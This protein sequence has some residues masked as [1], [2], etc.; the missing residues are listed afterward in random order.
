MVS[1]FLRHFSPIFFL[2]L[3]SSSEHHQ[4]LLK[5]DFMQKTIDRYE[6]KILDMQKQVDTLSQTNEVQKEE[7]ERLN[8]E[9]TDLTDIHQ[10]EMSS[11]K[12]DLKKLEDKL[13]YSFNE[14]WTEMVE[15]LEKLDTRVCIVND[16]RAKKNAKIHF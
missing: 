1:R 9:L 14:Y 6:L 12:N 2:V 5:L 11:M 15:K 10:V 16:S 13:I 3:Q 4:L 8:N 7:N